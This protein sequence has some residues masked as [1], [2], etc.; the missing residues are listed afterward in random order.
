MTVVVKTHKRH[1]HPKHSN[2]R[3]AHDLMMVVVVADVGRTAYIHDPTFQPHIPPPP[4]H[5]STSW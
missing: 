4:S 2:S 1:D 3:R 5:L